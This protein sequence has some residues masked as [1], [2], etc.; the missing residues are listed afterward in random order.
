MSATIVLP[1]KERHEATSVLLRGVSLLM[2][3]PAAVHYTMGPDRW[4]AF[5]ENLRIVRG[6]CLT[7]GD[8]SSTTSWLLKNALDH[9]HHHADVVN[10]AHWRAGYTGTQFAHG[11]RVVHDYNLRIGDLIFYGG[12]STVPEH[13]AMYVGGGKVFSHGGEGGPYILALD[14]RPDRHRGNARRYF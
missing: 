13:V 10:G 5:N 1:P 4:S 6:Q 7:H 8:C 9:V 11:R 3:D 14:Y 12:S 2:R